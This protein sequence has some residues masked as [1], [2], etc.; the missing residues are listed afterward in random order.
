MSTTF[1][2]EEP[3]RIIGTVT[4]VYSGLLVIGFALVLSHS[5]SRPAS[6]GP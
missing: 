4:K 1:S 3:P 6:S 2:F 5:K